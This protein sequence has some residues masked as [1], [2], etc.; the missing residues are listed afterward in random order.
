[1]LFRQIILN[2]IIIGFATGLLFTLFQQFQV[3]PIIFA[4]EKYELVDETPI[5][6]TRSDAHASGHAA[7]Q[8]DEATWAPEGGA[9]RLLYS[10]A[11]NISAGIGFAAILLAMMSLSQ[12]QGLSQVTLAKGLVWGIA[13]FVVFFVSPGLGLPPEIPG[14]EVAPLELRQWW[15]IFAVL[16]S[17]AG[18]ALIAFAPK[19]RKFAGVGFIGLPHVLGAPHTTGP[20]FNHP[21]PN[22][23]AVLSELHQQFIIAS[24]VANFVLWLCLGLVCAWAVNRWV[25][26]DVSAP[27]EA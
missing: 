9:E 15:W 22:A 20:K 17:A 11:S 23:V 21:D 4:A 5:T 3:A 26:K 12:L 6:A 27:A 24:G 16:A 13:G 2:A 19:L 7:H 10:I 14:I 18:L 1:M 25:L 8:H